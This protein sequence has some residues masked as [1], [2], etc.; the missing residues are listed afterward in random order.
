[1]T[2][3]AVGSFLQGG[4]V[5]GGTVAMNNQAVGDLVMLAAISTDSVN[6]YVN[7]ISGGGA[8]WTQI[9]V[10]VTGSTNSMIATLWMGTVTA[11]G[12]QTATLNVTGG[13]PTIRAAGNEFSS[14]VGSW[15]VDGSKTTLDSAGTNTWPSL[16]PA[17]SGDLYFGFAIDS[18]TASAGSTSGYSYHVTTQG[19]GCCFNPACSAAAQAPVWGDSGHEFGPM[20][21]IRETSAAAAE[22]IPYLSQY[23]GTF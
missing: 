11:T 4:A 10:H 16:T 22:P 21:L 8:T 23:M 19:N 13:G 15:A 20:V 9:G 18:G 5:G 2:F 17:G 14:T 1:M 7:S 12:T 6:N 3:A